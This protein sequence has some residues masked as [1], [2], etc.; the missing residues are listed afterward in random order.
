[1]QVLV[2]F[3]WSWSEVSSVMIPFALRNSASFS[4][5]CWSWSEVSS[6]TKDLRNC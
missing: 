4:S 1:M 5:F 2:P 6:V 3:C